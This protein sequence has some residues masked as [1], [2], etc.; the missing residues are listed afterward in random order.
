MAADYYKVLGVERN[1]SQDDIKRAFRRLAHEHHPDKQGGNAD[2]FKEINTAY[3]VLGNAEKRQQYD[4]FGAGFDQPGGGAGGFNWGG[5]GAQGYS[6]QFDF[7]DIGDIFGDM[8]GFGSNRS[9]RRS[10]AQDIQMEIAIGFREAYQGLEQEVNLYKNV[11]CHSCGGT[12]AE[13]GSKVEQC[14]VCKGNGRVRKVQNTMLGAIQVETICTNCQGTGEH[15]TKPCK[16]CGGVGLM[17]EQESFRLKIPAGIRDGQTLRFAGKGER[18]TKEGGA[19][20]LYV[21][22]RV[23]KDTTFDRDEDNLLVKV[24]VPFTTLALGGEVA[25]PTIEGSVRLKVPAGTASGKVFSLK[26]KGFTKLSGRGSGDLL[27]TVNV[28]VPDKLTKK[29]KEL[30]EE[31]DKQFGAERKKSW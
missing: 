12:G 29:Q 17:K 31:L 13:A 26:N 4:Q 1:A 7:G 27:I 21:V 16:K 6:Q 11:S 30:L 10:G 24:N 19:G 20:D 18:L 5:A 22:I 14:S 25:V 9:N 28:V 15:I 2:K 8:F 23:S 3:Q